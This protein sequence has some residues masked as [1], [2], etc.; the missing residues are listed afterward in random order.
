LNKDQQ[1]ILK[2]FNKTN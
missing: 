1:D 2:P